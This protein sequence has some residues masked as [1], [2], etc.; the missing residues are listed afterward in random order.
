MAKQ[1][2]RTYYNPFVTTG[3]TYENPRLGITD[4]GAFDK[5][6][7]QGL[8][9]GMDFMK[10]QEVKEKVDKKEREID[11]S[12]I[13]DIE[14]VGGEYFDTG[15]WNPN[16]D[17]KNSTKNTLVGF[18]DELLNKN[19]TEERKKE[20]RSSYQNLVTANASLAHILDVD[21]DSEL[22]SKNASNLN[23]LFV[24]QGTTLDDFRQAY[25]DGKAI[26]TVQNGAGGYLVN[27]KFIDFE[28]KINVNTVNEKMNLRSDNKVNE[29][30]TSFAGQN[31]F[32]TAPTSTAA[33]T[34]LN[35]DGSK[36]YNT[37]VTTILNEYGDSASVSAEQA[38]NQWAVNNQSM[39]PGIV[40]DMRSAEFLTK[41]ERTMLNAIEP[42][43]GRFN[44]NAVKSEARE[45][46][47]SANSEGRSITM[48]EATDQIMQQH[49]DF[50]DSLAQRYLK[51]EFLKKTAGFKVNPDTGIAELYDPRK[52]TSQGLTTPKSDDS[53]FGYVYSG[54]PQERYVELNRD[55]NKAVKGIANINAMTQGGIALGAA[56]QEL[57]DVEVGKITS[58]LNAAVTAEDK[59]AGG[60]SFKTKT[61]A[62][63]L[64]NSRLDDDGQFVLSDETT[65]N[66]TQTARLLE[67]INNPKAVIFEFDKNGEMT[68]HNFENATVKTLGNLVYNNLSDSKQKTFDQV[69]YD[70]NINMINLENNASKSLRV[71]ADRAK[72]TSFED[73]N[74]ISGFTSMR[75]QDKFAFLNATEDKQ[76][77]SLFN[78]LSTEEQADYML[79]LKK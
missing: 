58:I 17:I 26:P 21:S 6:F 37:K 11:A 8:Q 29:A 16:V 1:N 4:Y 24:D 39:L 57:L 38:A 64:F 63:E 42:R 10:E 22:Y 32:K 53:G 34:S 47:E 3:G 72:N 62:L 78:E 71:L 33:F 36:E 14:L 13:K 7:K 73:A 54:N 60:V 52:D 79:S 77:N 46:F 40:Q 70:K 75:V 5:G 61:E 31:Q 48:E 44:S 68:S 9:P 25:N 55:L 66:D 67:K 41:D 50:K 43:H 49:K 56:E 35:N 12:L 74:V 20:I 27:G 65:L 69:F 15:V 19:T 51:N 76:Q 30:A 28:N 59:K 2:N 45:L 18:R 23:E